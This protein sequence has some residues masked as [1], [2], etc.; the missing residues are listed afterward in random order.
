MEAIIYISLQPELTFLYD[1]PLAEWRRKTLPQ[2]LYLDLD[3]FSDRA[4]VQVALRLIDD[5]AKICLVIDAAQEGPVSHLLKIMEKAVKHKGKCCMLLNGNHPV[6]LRMGKILGPNFY[7]N[8]SSE[9]QQL[10]IKE[11]LLSASN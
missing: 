6:L 7:Q 4:T 11:F 1:K 9:N 8:L 10:I 2:S 5:A 3:N